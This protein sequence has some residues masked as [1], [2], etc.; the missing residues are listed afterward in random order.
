MLLTSNKQQHNEIT[1][2]KKKTQQDRQNTHKR[3]IE[4]NKNQ[5]DLQETPH[6]QDFIHNHSKYSKC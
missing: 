5:V 4:N 1:K 3:T 2:K 6:L